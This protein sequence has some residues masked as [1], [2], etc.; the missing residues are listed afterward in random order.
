[1]NELN[2][3]RGGTLTV[4]ARYCGCNDR[5]RSHF[6]Y[7][8]AVLRTPRGDLVMRPEGVEGSVRFTVLAVRL[9]QSYC[10]VYNEGMC[11]GRFSDPCDFSDARYGA[12]LEPFFPGC[13][14]ERAHAEETR[15]DQSMLP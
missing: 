2:A 4:E 15:S 12:L 6:P 7:V 8:L 14:P 5:P 1:M 9:G 13:K 3:M 10:D 11:Y